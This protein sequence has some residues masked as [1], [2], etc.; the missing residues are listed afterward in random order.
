MSNYRLNDEYGPSDWSASKLVGI[1]L[2][3]F[4]AGVILWTV[5]EI[6]QLFT[7]GSAFLVL[8]EIVPARIELVE[9]GLLLPREVLIYGL[10]IWAFSVTSKI[11]VMLLKNG[12]EYVERPRKVGK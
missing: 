12:L 4:G 11:G 1:L 8:D 6:F 7:H 2:T 9:N 10:P 3:M 5:V